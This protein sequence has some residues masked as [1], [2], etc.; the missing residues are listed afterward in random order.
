M[1]AAIKPYQVKV[2]DKLCEFRPVKGLRILEIGGASDGAVAGEV[3][4][5]GARE[6]I[7][8]NNRKDIKST[9][10]SENYK[11]YNMDARK[12]E[13]KDEHFDMVLGIAV[14]EHL[15]DLDIVCDEIYRVLKNDGLVYLHG[16]PLYTCSLGHHVWVHVDGVKYEFNG[17]NPIPDWYHLIFSKRE[18]KEYLI[19]GKNIPGDHAD[20][21]VHFIYDHPN[22]NR[23]K[24]EDYK[25]ILN[26]SKLKIVLFEE[27]DWKNPSKEILNLLAAKNHDPQLNYKTGALDIMLIKESIRGI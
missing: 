23:Y 6:V 26:E 16:G 1:N 5:R 24:Y 2:L 11:V 25:R 7:S 19:S 22:I 12:L 17:F 15:H 20:K 13:F 4:T 10:F 8:I 27:Q 21:I 3:L 14:L 9:I 18:M